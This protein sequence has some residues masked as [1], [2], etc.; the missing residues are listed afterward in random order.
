MKYKITL[1]HVTHNKHI[2]FFIL[3]KN[4]TLLCKIISEITITTWTNA[5]N[6]HTTNVK[7]GM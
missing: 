1:L 4:N 5:N 2:G 6:Q 3:P 7:D